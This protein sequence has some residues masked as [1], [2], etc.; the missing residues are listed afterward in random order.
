M[1]GEDELIKRAKVLKRWALAELFLCLA[2]LIEGLV[3]C[4]LLF[5]DH[6]IHH[7][8][9]GLRLRNAGI[10]FCCFVL[11]EL[12]QRWCVRKL[13]LA[14]L[15]LDIDSMS[16]ITTEQRRAATLRRENLKAVCKRP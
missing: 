9:D 12:L 14:Q 2:M 10:A 16:F 15:L 6:L 1:R 5:S 4:H 13:L 7:A 8:Y 11:A 3:F